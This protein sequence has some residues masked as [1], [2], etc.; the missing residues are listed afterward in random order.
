MRAGWTT[1]PCPGCGESKDRKAVSCCRDCMDLI[2]DG[3]KFR[4]AA[5]IGGVDSVLYGSAIYP[6]YYAMN[7]TA[8]ANLRSAFRDVARGLMDAEGKG[9]LADRLL[10]T[11]RPPGYRDA[12]TYVSDPLPGLVWMR[13]DRRDALNRLNLAVSAALKTARDAGIRDGSSILQRLHAGEIG[14]ADF[15]K[16]R[17]A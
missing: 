14:L 1:K 7:S 15:E 8:D 9:Y 12:T 11:E 3:R 13:P 5:R 4:E 6:G 17:P 16:W 10:L 2:A